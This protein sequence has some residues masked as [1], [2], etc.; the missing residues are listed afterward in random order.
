[1]ATDLWTLPRIAEVIERQ[2]GRRFH[3]GHVWWMLQRLTWAL[4]RPARQAAERDEAASRRWVR[5]RW[6][7]VKKT[8]D[9][10]A[11]GS[12]SRTKAASPSSRSSGEPGRRAARPLAFG[13][14]GRPTRLYFQTRPGTYT[15]ATLLP[16]LRALQRH[17]RGL[18]IIL[19]W[20][21]LGAHTSRR[22]RA[23]LA[24]QRAWLTVERLPAYA[25]DLNPVEPLRRPAGPWR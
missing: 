17:F 5:R 24:G 14:D 22:M 12:T 10:S 9:A 4:Q 15:A 3:P 16:F 19:L 20:D 13:W 2:T 11:P 25:P 7:A 1:L 21:G 18:R 8:P 6:P 23:H